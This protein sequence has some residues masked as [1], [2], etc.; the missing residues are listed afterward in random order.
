M[1]FDPT[2]R[3]LLFDTFNQTSTP[4]GVLEFWNINIL[5]LATGQMQSVFPP[6]PNGIDLGNPSFSKSTSSRFLFDMLDNNAATD[7]VMGADFFQG[8]YGQIVGPI[9]GIGY[10][11]YSG[12]GT[13]I[14]YHRI[15]QVGGVLHHVIEQIAVDTNGTGPLGN[16]SSYVIDA[17]YPSWFV[18]GN[19]VTGVEERALPG[20]PAQVQLVQNYPNPFNPTTTIRFGL[21]QRAH[22]TLTVFN[23]LGQKVATLVNGDRE[24]GYHEVQFD[25]TNLASGAYFCRIQSGEAVRTMKLLLLR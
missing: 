11:T 3:Y 15:A 17:T 1:S 16:A 5:D 24:A 10:P 20:T 13:M 2:G 7:M 18:I 12:D 23:T 4:S 9:N 6:Q 14:A 19:R 22:V 21:P 8:T 25:A